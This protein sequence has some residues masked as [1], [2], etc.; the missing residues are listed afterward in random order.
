MA[1]SYRLLAW[2]CASYRRLV[3]RGV[4]QQ[5]AKLRGKPDVA[6][7]RDAL[8]SG[9]GVVVAR[10]ASFAPE[11]AELVDELVAAFARL[12]EQPIKRDPTCRGKLAIARALIELVHWHDDV[13]AR[14]VAF[15]QKEPAYGGT[16]DTAGELRGTCGLAYANLARHD[17]PDVLA[18]LLAD[19]ERVA[20]VAAA[21]GLGGAGRP[22]ASALLRYKLLIGDDEPEVLAACCESLLGLGDGLAFVVRLLAGNDDRAEVAA[23][24]LGG[25]RDARA[26]EPLTA[27][28]ERCLGE[29]RRRVGYV[30]LAL[31]RDDDATARLIAV[32]K[33]GDRD[34][35][36]A[37]AKALATFKDDPALRDRVVAAAPRALAREIRE[38]FAV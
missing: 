10:A 16:V 2:T 33:D 3:P 1:P 26:S 15:V 22:D 8:R 29:Q 34:D 25:T 18:E 28:C 21:R 4:D 27:W 35:A 31:L 14:G 5:L 9:V 38:L 7:L 6:T 37:A 17:A 30:A 36:L 11:H 24:A 19:G 13:F 23:L 32:M 20:R 12:C